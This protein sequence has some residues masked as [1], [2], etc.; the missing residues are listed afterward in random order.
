MGGGDG[1]DQYKSAAIRNGWRLIKEADQGNTVIQIVTWK[2]GEIIS[3]A[4]W[5]MKIMFIL[6]PLDQSPFENKTVYH[7]NK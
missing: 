1:G 7:G 4:L 6:F 5:P 2:K 3:A